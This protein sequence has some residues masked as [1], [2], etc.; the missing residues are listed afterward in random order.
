MPTLAAVC[1]LA[2]MFTTKDLVRAIDAAKGQKSDP[3]V[4]RSAGV[5][6]NTLRE[7]RK[8]GRVPTLERASRLADAVGLELAIRPKGH[9]LDPLAAHMAFAILLMLTD[10]AAREA[11]VSDFAQQYAYWADFLARNPKDRDALYRGFLAGASLQD[12]HPAFTYTR[13]GAVEYRLVVVDPAKDDDGAAPGNE[14]ADE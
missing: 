3:E 7:I 11:F 1:Y 14:G 8:K 6:P 12:V 2:D 5:G 9:Y 4:S 13:Y 10:E